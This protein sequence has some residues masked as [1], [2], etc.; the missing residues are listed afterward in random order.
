MLSKPEWAWIEERLASPYGRALLKVDGFDVSLYVE[1]YKK[2]RYTIVVYVNGSWSG[3]Q[4]RE[5]CE[6][7]RRFWR[8]TRRCA[9]TRKHLAEWCRLFGKRAAEKEKKKSTIDIWYPD[10]P[11]FGALRRHLIANNKAIAF[12]AGFRPNPSTE[13]AKAT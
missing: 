1:P 5:D 7:R 8:R 10:W 12:A 6:E 2:L 13:E 3:K 11:S 4:L 9:M